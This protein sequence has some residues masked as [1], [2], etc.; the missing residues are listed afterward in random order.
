MSIQAQSKI[1]DR[2]SWTVGVISHSVSLPFKNIFKK[3]LNLGLVLGAEYTYQQKAINSWHQRLELG[4]YHHKELNTALWIKTDIV[5]RF[6]AENGLQGDVQL[7]LGYLYDIPAYKTYSIENGQIIEPKLG[8]KGALIADFGLGGGYNIKVG[9]N[10]LLTP[11]I[12]YEAMFQMPYTGF[13]P[14]FPHSLLHVGS[15]LKL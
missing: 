14:V 4:W 15:R 6:T 2:T 9:D 1:W 12:K 5:N 13:V 11:F 7:G 10:F 3:P 8:G